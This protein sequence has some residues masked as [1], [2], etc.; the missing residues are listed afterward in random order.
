MAPFG[1][2]KFLW[3]LRFQNRL[4]WFVVVHAGKLP[5][6]LVS[7]PWSKLKLAAHMPPMKVRRMP[8]PAGFVLKLSVA[9]FENEALLLT[10]Q[11]RSWIQVWA[12]AGTLRASS[13]T[14]ATASAKN[15]LRI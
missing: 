11:Y 4:Y 15:D 5:A 3:R 7:D 6:G 2:V 12:D 1:A 13:K 8:I 9:P 10:P 14:V